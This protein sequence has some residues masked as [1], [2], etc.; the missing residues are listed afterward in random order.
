MRHYL[1]LA[2]KWAWLITVLPLLAMAVGYQY[3][4]SV[5]PTYLA[6]TTLIVGQA[7]Q[8][9]NPS[10][11]EFSVASQ[12]AQAYTLLVKQQP[13]LQATATAT[14]WPGS[15]ESLA[16]AVSATAIGAQ[17]IQISV[18]DADP[19]RAQVIANELARQLILRSPTGVEQKQMDDQR[20]FV[21]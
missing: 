14:H 17:L 9:P 19:V 13:I 6:S 10:S 4:R 3:A 16:D 8:N 1:A 2:R 20:A 5:Q 12:L 11:G 7:L 18:T 21:S 15:W